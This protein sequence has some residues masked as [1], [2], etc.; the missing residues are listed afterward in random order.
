MPRSNSHFLE[1]TKVLYVVTARPRTRE[2]GRFWE[3]LNDG[4]IQNQD[5]DGREIVASMKRAVTKGEQVE[6]YETCYCSP[7]LRHE[8]STVYDRFFEGIQAEP[9]QTPIRLDGQSFW[10][11]LRDSNGG[12]TTRT[13]SGAGRARYVP[14]R[15]L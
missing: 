11:Y 13:V 3:L 9:I 6:W 7:P 15:I 1:R 2:L 5:P 14:I 4:T 10:D 12:E 8:R